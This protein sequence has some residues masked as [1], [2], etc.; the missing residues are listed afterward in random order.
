MIFV[1]Q[2][3]ILRIRFGKMLF[4]LRRLL[5]ILAW[6][7]LVYQYDNIYKS[8][9]MKTL[10]ILIMC[11]LSL[12]SE[13]QAIDSTVER[14]VDVNL[15]VISN[16]L[17]KKENSLQKIS[18]AVN[19]FTDLTGIVSENKEVYYGQFHPTVKDLEA[20]RKWYQYNK[21][22]LFWDREIKSVLLYKKVKPLIF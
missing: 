14:I 20:W 11:A 17:D 13:A 15:N 21:D 16:Y 22:Y 5:K 12:Q 8:C 3:V 18:D 10:F 7:C 9:I 2:M 1:R 4:Y 6:N 19:F